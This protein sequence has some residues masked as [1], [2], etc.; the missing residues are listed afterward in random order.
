MMKPTT[1]SALSFLKIQK[2]LLNQTSEV[3]HVYKKALLLTEKSHVTSSYVVNRIKDKERREKSDSQT[4]LAS[5]FFDILFVFKKS[6]P[7]CEKFKDILLR[8]KNS[9]GYH[10][11][12]LSLDGGTYKEFQKITHHPIEKLTSFDMLPA[13]FL[14]SKAKD[15]AAPITQGYLSYDLF[16][17]RVV[18]ILEELEKKQ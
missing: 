7:Y 14:V 3:A 11:D 1:D 10:V 12:A 17:E 4:K 13:V 16:R 9:Y 15:I 8:F 6:C 2:A 5:R 18:F